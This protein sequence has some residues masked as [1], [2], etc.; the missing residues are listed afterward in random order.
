MSILTLI[1]RHNSILEPAYWFEVN[2][3]S[4]M[5][6]F[7]LTTIVVLDFIVIFEKNSLVT[8]QFFLKTYLATYLTVTTF[9]CTIYMVWTMILEYNHP[10]P[11]VGALVNFPLRIVSMV[12]LSMMLPRAFSREE[13]TKKK[14]RNFAM[15]QYAWLMVAGS[16]YIPSIIYRKLENTDAQCV[17][18]FLIPIA[19]I[20]TNLFLSKMMNTIKG[21]NDERANLVVTTHINLS[22]G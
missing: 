2:I 15:F 7:S 5:A 20:S 1:P 3:P 22:Y 8:I 21:I 14:L 17:V 11:H 12:S 16:K 19:K 18:A 10:M 9:Y 6:C 13:E 4:A